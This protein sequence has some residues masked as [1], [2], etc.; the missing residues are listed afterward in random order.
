MKHV[1]KTRLHCLILCQRPRHSL[2]N[3]FIG[4]S[5]QNPYLLQSH[6][7]F[8]FIHLGSHLVCGADGDFLQLCIVVHISG[9]ASRLCQ[10]RN[11]ASV[12]FLNHADC[13]GNKISQVV[14]QVVVQSLQHYLVCEHSVLSE[15]VF[16]EEEVFQSIDSVSVNEHNRIDYILT[17][18]CL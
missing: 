13:S 10:F 5:N 12:V 2:I 6:V 4:S 18:G 3:V 11:E 7:E 16:P 1:V 9:A 15:G 17:L 8:E 14:C